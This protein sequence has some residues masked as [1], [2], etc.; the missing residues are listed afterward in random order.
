VTRFWVALLLAACEPPL[1]LGPALPAPLPLAPVQA[2]APLPPRHAASR[3][4]FD[5]MLE[6]VSRARGLPFRRAVVYARI[7]RDDLLARVRA[8]VAREVPARAIRAEGLVQKLLGLF[9]QRGDYEAE[10]YALLLGS[11]AGYYE[12]ADG[13]MYVAADLDDGETRATLSHELVH[14]LQDQRWGLRAHAAYVEGQDDRSTAFSALAEGDATSVTED[15]GAAPRSRAQARDETDA[16][17]A[18]RR[19]LLAPYVAGTRFVSALR[20]QGGW[21]AVD[22]AWATPPET[23]EQIL[24]PEKWQAHEP[25]DVVSDPPPP[26]TDLP[27]LEATTYGELG[28]Q[29]TLEGWAGATSASASGWGGDRLA[30]YASGDR[31]ALLW[32]LRFDDA[33]P[34][35]PDAIA[36]RVFTS[37]RASLAHPG[38][39]LPA[40]TDAV[41]E[42]RGGNGV[43]AVSRVGRDVFVAVGT[44]TMSARGWQPV[45]TCDE[46]LA[47]CRRASLAR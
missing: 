18:L 13:T 44:V 38:R 19:A 4:L 5:Q 21:A 11:L 37:M 33:S 25:A 20:R 32:H 41:C 6:R 45:M 9:P 28:L 8:H 17:R 26:A 34:A 10:T 7:D 46:A 35:P 22:A 14:A 39:V 40:A 29:L 12:P 15:L 27:L 36:L 47:W 42:G 24:H 2:D 31:A 16:P 30:L 3:T 23:T 43:L 1:P